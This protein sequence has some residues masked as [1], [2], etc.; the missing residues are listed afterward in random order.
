MSGA[1]RRRKKRIIH[2]M[3]N[4]L[5]LA[6]TFIGLSATAPR[7]EA[8]G[9]LSFLFGR[10]DRCDRRDRSDRWDR[11]DR[12]DRHDRPIY[13]APRGDWDDRCAPRTYS[14]GYDRGFRGG[15]RRDYRRPVLVREACETRDGFSSAPRFS[16]WR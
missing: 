3:K 8:G 11:R 1:W 10:G 12:W 16:V 9:L 7:A 13:Y 6:L 2:L 4:A 15:D 14:G 5:L